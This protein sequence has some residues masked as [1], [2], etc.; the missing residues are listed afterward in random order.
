M[1]RMILEVGPP[2]RR[3]PLYWRELQRIF[4]SSLATSVTRGA[5]VLGGYRLWRLAPL[6]PCRKASPPEPFGHLKPLLIVICH[7]RHDGTAAD[8]SQLSVARR[9]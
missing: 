5:G 2:V 9:S 4:A 3:R 6:V 7:Q 1:S 8:A